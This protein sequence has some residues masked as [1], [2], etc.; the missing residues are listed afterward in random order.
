M[1]SIILPVI[2]IVP[3]SWTLPGPILSAQYSQPPL[4]P[5][6]V[7][8]GSPLLIYQLLAALQFSSLAATQG[9]RPAQRAPGTSFCVSAGSVLLPGKENRRES[10][11]PWARNPKHP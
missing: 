3:L 10:L 7:L 5:E 1:G 9:S 11:P 4:S 8:Y 2:V 6:L